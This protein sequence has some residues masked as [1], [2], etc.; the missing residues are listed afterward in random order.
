[1]NLTNRAEQA[2]N[3][4]IPPGARWTKIRRSL[5]N[6]EALIEAKERFEERQDFVIVLRVLSKEEIQKLAEKTRVIRGKCGCF[7]T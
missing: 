5:I 1:V 6:P 3:K 7:L 4:G 2:K